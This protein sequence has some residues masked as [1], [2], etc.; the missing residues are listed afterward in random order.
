MELE[1]LLKKHDCKSLSFLN[2]LKSNNL[3]VDKVN[4][5][6]GNTFKPNIPK[7]PKK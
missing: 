5:Q 1:K 2:S 6:N 3:K 7:Q 4:K